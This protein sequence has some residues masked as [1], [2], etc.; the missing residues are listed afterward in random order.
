MSTNTPNTLTSYSTTSAPESNSD[1]EAKKPLAL[2]SVPH[3]GTT[4]LDLSSGSTSVKLDHLGPMVV[5]VDGTLSR[6]SNWDGMAQVERENTLRV[7]GRRNKVRLEA[8]K[9]KEKREGEEG[10]NEVKEGKKFEE[11][12]EGE[13]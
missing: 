7:I 6:I 4:T 13:K 11:K 1:T 8:L 10:G 2:P 5:N 12:V 9:K 3:N